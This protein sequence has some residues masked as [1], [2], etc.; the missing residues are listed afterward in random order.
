MTLPA[1][2]MTPAQQALQVAV[3]LGMSFHRVVDEHLTTPGHYV[4]SSP[5]CFIL[6]YDATHEGE[7]AVFVTLGVGSLKHFLSI[8]PKRE[9]RRWLG[10]CREDGGETHWLPYQRLRAKGKA[11]VA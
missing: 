6:A 3:R 5:E 2:D 11:E 4:Y 1:I 7:L 10:F 8:D 9:E